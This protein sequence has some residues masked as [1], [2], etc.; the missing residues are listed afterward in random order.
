MEFLYFFGLLNLKDRLLDVRNDR[1]DRMFGWTRPAGAGAPALQRQRL[2]LLK[3][4]HDRDAATL[5]RLTSNRR[6]FALGHGITVS[7]TAHG[8]SIPFPTE[9]DVAFFIIMRNVSSARLDLR[10]MDSGVS[11]SVPFDQHPRD[12]AVL[13]T[14]LPLCLM[15]RIAASVSYAPAGREKPVLEYSGI[16][17]EERPERLDRS[18][19]LGAPDEYASIDIEDGGETLPK[20]SSKVPLDFEVGAVRYRVHENR[21]WKIRP[22]SMLG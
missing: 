20:I 7:C 18:A 17:F 11:V 10:D 16:M 14:Y 19:I 6:L 9:Q 22:K 2:R 5:A 1:L 15:R 8:D 4:A 3:Y 21:L 12:H 13:E